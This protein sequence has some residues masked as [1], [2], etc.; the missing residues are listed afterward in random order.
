MSFRSNKMNINIHEKEEK[1]SKAELHYSAQISIMLKPCKLP[2]LP[3]HP[4]PPHPKAKYPDD[5]FKVR[6]IVYFL[7][8]KIF[9]I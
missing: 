2:G 9:L 5:G 1:I 4:T 6:V 3:T 8:V 7:S